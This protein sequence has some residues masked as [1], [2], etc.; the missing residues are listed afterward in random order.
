LPELPAGFWGIKDPILIRKAA[1]P[2]FHP[3]WEEWAK[4]DRNS[5]QVRA[6]G[7]EHSDMQ[8]SIAGPWMKRWDIVHHN[9]HTQLL[10]QEGLAFHKA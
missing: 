5:A 2:S 3:D 9:Q 7:E 1:D 6:V 10:D 4:I 8:P